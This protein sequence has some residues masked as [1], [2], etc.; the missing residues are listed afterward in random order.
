[1]LLKQDAVSTVTSV[2]THGT[3]KT[4]MP[5]FQLYSNVYLLSLF[6]SNIIEMIF[7]ISTLF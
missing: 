4:R 7:F 5:K 1:M 3:E 6:D 2:E